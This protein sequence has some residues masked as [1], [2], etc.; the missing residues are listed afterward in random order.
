[1]KVGSVVYSRAGHDVGKAYA[2][3]AVDL[4]KG[5]VAVSDGD[6]H[7]LEKPKIK[8]TKH[9]IYKGEDIPI[10]EKVEKGE[11]HDNDLIYYLK[12]FKREG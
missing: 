5:Y 2:V 1:M 4:A 11:L 6:K 9:L 10:A 12:S 3:V 8:N 7:R